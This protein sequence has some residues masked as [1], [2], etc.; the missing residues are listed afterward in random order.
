VVDVWED[1]AAFER[2]AQERIGP[3]SG[4]HGFQPPTIERVS[5]D[6]RSDGD[7]GTASLLQIVRLPFDGDGFHAMDDQV[8]PGGQAPGDLVHHVNGPGPDGKWV[9]IDTWNSRE[10]RDRFIEE[11]VLPT[12]PAD[13]PPLATEDLEVHNTMG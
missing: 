11:R 6:E 3:I 2:F 1:E 10:A 12:F 13:A 7:A 4:R 5:V 8:R 9:V